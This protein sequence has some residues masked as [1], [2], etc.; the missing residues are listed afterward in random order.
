M[1]PSL[2]REGREP[3]SPRC[4]AITAFT[5]G[6]RVKHI[7]K[8]N[9]KTFSDKIGVSQGTLSEFREISVPCPM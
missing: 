4:A 9:Q 6:D 8:I 2:A 1:A 5:I 3:I 7:R